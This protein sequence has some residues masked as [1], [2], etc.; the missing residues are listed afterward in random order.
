MLQTAKLNGRDLSDF[1]YKILD[2]V[3]TYSALNHIPYYIS[4]I[5]RIIRVTKTRPGGIIYIKHEVNEQY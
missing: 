2:M 3:A 5:K 4:S 1:E